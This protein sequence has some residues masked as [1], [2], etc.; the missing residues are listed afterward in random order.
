VNESTLKLAAGY[1]AGFAL[2]TQLMRKKVLFR[3]IPLASY[4][5]FR[6]NAAQA[7]REGEA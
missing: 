1:H 5:E 2:L 7:E 3:F 4:G 6:V